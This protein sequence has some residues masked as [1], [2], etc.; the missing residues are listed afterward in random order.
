MGSKGKRYSPKFKFNVVLEALKSEKSDAEVARADD[1]HPAAVSRWKGDFM[2]QGPEA[3]GGSEE[4]KEHEE[5]IG[6]LERMLGRKEV[7]LA[8]LKSLFFRELSLDEKIELVAEDREQHG[9]NRCHPQGPSRTSWALEVQELHDRDGRVRRTCHD[10][11]TNLIPP[12]FRNSRRSGRRQHRP[13]TAAIE[14]I[15]GEHAPGDE[16]KSNG[17]QSI[18]SADLRNPSQT[19]RSPSW[20]VSDSIHGD[21]L[22]VEVVGHSHQ[23][24]APVGRQEAHTGTE[25]HAA[26]YAP[27][28]VDD[29]PGRPGRSAK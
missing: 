14:K 11:R 16:H 1:V 29:F 3:F 26:Q 24:T 10:S 17:R 4:V 8:L 2:E 6:Q 15:E 25:S 27:P 5:R 22:H 28:P 23:E 9:L 7:E 21:P 20:F 13:T 12:V 18:E 19:I